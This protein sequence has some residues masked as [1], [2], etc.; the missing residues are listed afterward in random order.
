MSYRFLTDLLS[1]AD[2][3]VRS[4]QQTANQ[5]RADLEEAFDKVSVEINELVE[6]LPQ[7]PSVIPPLPVRRQM[8]PLPKV[9]K[10]RINIPKLNIPLRSVKVSPE[11]KDVALRRAGI[12]VSAILTTFFD[13]PLYQQQVDR[14]NSISQEKG[15][16]VV[17]VGILSSDLVEQSAFSAVTG[18]SQPD[19]SSLAP[20]EVAAA[21]KEIQ[22]IREALSG[23]FLVRRRRNIDFPGEDVEGRSLRVT[24]DRRG[25]P[26]VVETPNLAP[27]I[28]Q[29]TSLYYDPTY[30]EELTLADLITHLRNYEND[31]DV[32]NYRFR[33]VL[34]N[35]SGQRRL[36]MLTPSVIGSIRR[37]ENGSDLQ[38]YL[39]II[40]S[41]VRGATIGSE[42][43]IQRRKGE[44]LQPIVTSDSKSV[45]IENISSW[46]LQKWMKKSGKHRAGRYFKYQLRPEYRT[47]EE[48][49]GNSL[50]E[51]L[52]PFV[53]SSSQY[54]CFA[55]VLVQIKD[56]LLKEDRSD[57]YQFF[58]Y[59]LCHY[60]EM[61]AKLCNNDLELRDISAFLKSHKVK[62]VL[63]AL[64]NKN[65]VTLSDLEKSYQETGVAR[66]SHQRQ[67]V[68]GYLEEDYIFEIHAG[69]LG[70]HYFLNTPVYN[71]EGDVVSSGPWCWTNYGLEQYFSRAQEYH[72]TGRPF[73][74]N[75]LETV[76]INDPRVSQAKRIKNEERCRSTFE[77][78]RALFILCDAFE[79]KPAEVVL[80]ECIRPEI[81]DINHIADLTSGFMPEEDI[82]AYHASKIKTWPSGFTRSS[83]VDPEVVK[84]TYNV[85]YADTEAY[86]EHGAHT[87]E[88]NV[89]RLHYVRGNIMRSTDVLPTPTPHP[90]VARIFDLNYE[91]VEI[92]AEDVVAVDGD[93]IVYRALCGIVEASEPDTTT[94]RNMDQERLRAMLAR[95]R[96]LNGG[97]IDI[98]EAEYA[99]VYK[100]NILVYFHNLGFD[101]RM[102]LK[103]PEVT[104][105]SRIGTERSVKTF[106]IR[107]RGYSITFKDSYSIISSPLSS[108]G[109]MFGLDCGKGVS[110]YDVYTRSRL[111]KG[112]IPTSIA[113]ENIP[114]ESTELF[115]ELSQNYRYVGEGGVEMFKLHE[116]DSYYCS[117]DVLTLARGF[118][119]MRVRM[120]TLGI[121]IYNYLSA[122]ACADAVYSAAGCYDG[123]SPVT[124]VSRLYLNEHI[125]GGRCMVAI[126][127]FTD[128]P[129]PPHME[130]SDIREPIM[131]SDGN[132]LYPSASCRV[133]LPTGTPTSLG[134]LF[135]EDTQDMS[136]EE[137]MELFRTEGIAYN[138]TIQITKVKNALT[139]PLI[140]YRGKDGSRVTTNTPWEMVDGVLVPYLIYVDEVSLEDIVKEH[141][142]EFKVLAGFV[143]KTG[144]TMN[145]TM[146]DVVSSLYEMRKKLKMN[147][148]PLQECIKLVLNGAYG[149]TLMKDYSEDTRFVKGGLDSIALHNFIT[150]NQNRIVGPATEYVLD[151]GELRSVVKILKYKYSGYNNSVVGTR[152]LSMSKRI[153][154]TVTSVFQELEDKY[155]KQIMFY[156]DT[157]SVHHLDAYT[158]EAC[159]AFRQKHGCEMFGSELGQFSQDIALI[160]GAVSATI[161]RGIYVGKKVYY[162][163]VV[164]TMKDGS[165]ITKDHIRSKGI[166][167][168]CIQPALDIHN[169][170]P[171][172]RGK[173][174]PEYL[175]I[176]GFYEYLNKG[177]A[178]SM[179]LVASGKVFF[180]YTSTN[181]TIKRRV[182]VRTLQFPRPGNARKI[183]EEERK[184]KR[185]L[186]RV[187]QEAQEEEARNKAILARPTPD[188]AHIEYTEYGNR[189]EQLRNLEKIGLA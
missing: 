97:S 141:D 142:I 153:M 174:S 144:T 184:E 147:R 189:T 58:D 122:S 1:G 37:G 186:T 14:A 35:T 61:R 100:R 41:T 59:L 167:A 53:K 164:F 47:P 15:S 72:A 27:Q 140:N 181:K 80:T 107:F 91:P 120:S 68:T 81:P 109:Q 175:N 8:P 111:S 93:N 23:E 54:D 173:P 110:P 11:Q 99:R 31:I 155:Q 169:S 180:D 85:F 102:L 108:F 149:Y 57:Y 143:W 38:E 160:P 157:D 70:N 159:E 162:E 42:S 50:E 22:S 29:G 77:L 24:L 113:L 18:V 87:T 94:A 12:S 130:H 185:R 121:D 16:E 4:L 89:S 6:S 28:I 51:V 64:R 125:S 88:L 46:S 48:C 49:V 138:I 78:L 73:D 66:G 60:S 134:N 182:F 67:I 133:S 183:L 114:E 152:V 131:P 63:T 56:Q 71:Q 62:L 25:K 26:V 163:Q 104:P 117:Q 137:I 116:Y 39:N 156:T 106:Q 34:T 101:I 52:E 132:S 17:P 188:I 96:S 145:A 30:G 158:E 65:H 92:K 166:N 7:M 176:P 69:L 118:E 148:N 21:D 95:N 83:K 19:V 74:F 154:N 13:P 2:S 135:C 84:E 177:N 45:E 86:F 168:D 170:T 150:N 128:T 115:L 33:L 146:K 127:R 75:F 112:V 139:F 36:Y 165:Q 124:G 136:T 76:K 123:V 161:V 98:F 9:P 43:E 187:R 32:V 90:E 151:N 82:D 3:F 105:I 44:N 40:A 126:N 20:S 179:D 119:T 178:F 171:T 79:L 103:C 55:Q 10:P 129:L 172:R 5:I